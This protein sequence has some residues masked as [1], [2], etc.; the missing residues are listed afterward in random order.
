MT[1]PK[2]PVGYGRKG[3]VIR[4]I[5]ANVRHH[6]NLEEKTDKGLKVKSRK[7]DVFTGGT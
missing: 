5:R 4:F 7:L 3:S 1:H 6:E 2:V